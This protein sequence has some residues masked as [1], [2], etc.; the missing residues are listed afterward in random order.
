MFAFFQKDSRDLSGL[1][2][3]SWL[4][5]GGVMGCTDVV[6]NALTDIGG[7][8]SPDSGGDIDLPDFTDLRP[9]DD[10][11]DDSEIYSVDTNDAWA[12][13]VDGQETGADQDAIENGADGETNIGECEPTIWYADIDNDGYGDPEV[14]EEGCRP[15]GRYVTQGGDCDDLNRDIKPSAIEV[16]DGI[17]N[18]CDGGID[19][20]AIDATDYCLDLDGDGFGQLESVSLCDEP[21][22]WSNE[23]TDCDDNNSELVTC[24]GAQ[25]C[26]TEAGVGCIPE[27]TCSSNYDC[28]APQS[29]YCDDGF[30]AA[31]CEE[32]RE[33]VIV[34]PNILFVLDRSQGMN[35]SIGRVRRWNTLVETIAH[36][37]AEDDRVESAHYGLV[38]F[39]DRD[40]SE[41]GSCR[42]REVRCEQAVMSIETEDDSFNVPLN[43]GPGNGTRISS[44]LTASMDRDHWLSPGCPGRTRN[45]DCGMAQAA[46]DP[47]LADSSRA[48]YIVLLT[49]G[50]QHFC[51]QGLTGCPRTED[52]IRELN[53]ELGVETFVMGFRA[54]EHGAQMRAWAEAGGVDYG[55]I[56]N[57]YSEHGFM[58]IDSSEEFTDAL[59]DVVSSI[60]CRVQVD[61]PPANAED[62]LAFLD[63]TPIDLDPENGWTL[64]EDTV[65]FHG[66]ACRMI[67]DR[68][69]EDIRIIYTCGDKE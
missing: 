8:E 5:I 54:V 59:W 9:L 27:G 24:G 35:S 64:D 40:D 50:G 1:V 22:S 51:S 47:G 18:D 42:E 43:V 58:L 25:V 16:C 60:R 30:C 23:C 21:E 20:G 38:L 63:T 32:E 28:M 41:Q 37:V 26:S 10:G 13:G 12:D 46:R 44:L 33:P 2:L 3:W 11:G 4:V 36:I 7:V 69:V 52:V 66:A 62:L 14:T 15:T 17:D 39:P 45:P 29:L 6:P 53:V 61:E 56:G 49:A 19:L 65:T 68:E 48:N 31:R 34:Q 57:R 67:Q 55:T